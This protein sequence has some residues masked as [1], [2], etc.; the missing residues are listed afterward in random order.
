MFAIFRNW[1]FIYK[2]IKYLA[3]RISRFISITN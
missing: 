3:A 2:L 1:D